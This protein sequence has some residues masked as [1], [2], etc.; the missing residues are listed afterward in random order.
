M[1]NAGNSINSVFQRRRG[2]SEAAV[3]NSV[4]RGMVRAGTTLYMTVDVNHFGQ[5]GND[6]K[7][8]VTVMKTDM[9][10]GFILLQVHLAAVQNGSLTCTNITSAELFITIAC[11][12]TYNTSSVHSVLINTDLSLLFAKLPIGVMK[13]PS[14]IMIEENLPFQRYSLPVVTTKAQSEISRYNYSSPSLR[15]SIAPTPMTTL[16]VTDER[17]ANRD[18]SQPELIVGYI[19]G[20][21]LLLWCGYHAYNW[22]TARWIDLQKKWQKR[23]FMMHGR[24]LL[25]EQPPHGFHLPDRLA[26]YKKMHG[27]DTIEEMRTRSNTNLLVRQRGTVY[28]KKVLVT[29]KKAKK[30]AHL[31]SVL[32]N[33]T[34]TNTAPLGWYVDGAVVSGAYANSAPIQGM[35]IDQS[36]FFGFATGNVNPPNSVCSDDSG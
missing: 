5:N 13:Q 30:G 23:E 4:T 35:R 16:A 14:V 28:A 9:Q 29:K 10:T 31:D 7:T 25:A 11:Q 33:D 27:A 20:A 6:S 24:R 36:A 2:L 12:V 3:V 15:R 32:E 17:K 18:L 34:P 21:C 26:L 8:S 19:M 1:S 22:Y